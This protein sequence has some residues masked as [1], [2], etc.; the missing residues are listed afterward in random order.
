MTAIE[1]I[2]LFV[3]GLVLTVKGADWLTEGASSVARRLRVSSMVIGLT[4]VAVGT[5][6]PELVVSCLSA[7]RDQGDMAIGNV[8]GSNIFNTLVIAGLT[9]LVS[10][11]LCSKNNIR[12]DVPFCLVASIA[13]FALTAEGSLTRWDGVLLLCFLVIFISYTFA[14][15]RS[16]RSSAG[17]LATPPDE[18]PAWKTTLSLVG[19]LVCL[20]LGGEWFVG[21][22]SGIARCLGVSEGVIALTIV[23]AGTSMPELVTSVVAAHKGDTAMALG[24]V[25]GSNLLNIFLV[26]GVASCIRP[27][28]LGSIGSV[29]FG[30]LLGAMTL[31]WLFCRFNDKSVRVIN[32]WE[33]MLLLLCGV[34]YYAQAVIFA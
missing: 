8:V 6:A 30:T 14:I 20:A 29:D 4:V 2:G 23:A 17:A 32:R 24:N 19:G 10:P 18:P 31:L 3:L 13:L 16:S 15:A 34:A 25:V 21:G 26:L 11:L 9:A 12:Y 5:S 22:A 28:S 1:S 33:G 7:A 27:L